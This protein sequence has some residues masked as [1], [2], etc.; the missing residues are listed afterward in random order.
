MGHL[1]NLQTEFAADL[2]VIEVFE[3]AD[4]TAGLLACAEGAWADANFALVRTEPATQLSGDFASGAPF[5][6]YPT[7]PLVDLRARRVVVPDCWNYPTADATDYE[8]CI[9]DHLEAD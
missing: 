4:D 1:A 7:L 5:T 2:H 9:A 8:A 6:G 3:S